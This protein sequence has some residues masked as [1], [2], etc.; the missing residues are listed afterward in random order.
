MVDGY[1][2]ISGANNYFESYG[3]SEYE[4]IEQTFTVAGGNIEELYLYFENNE[5]DP[6]V[7][8]FKI[9]RIDVI[10]TEPLKYEYNINNEGYTAPTTDNWYLYSSTNLPNTNTITVRVTN[11]LGEQET[12][13]VTYGIAIILSSSTNEWTNENVTVTANWSGDVTQKSLTCTGT[14]GTD[15]TLNGTT[16]VIVMTNKQTITATALDK[17]GNTITKTLKVSIIDKNAPTVQVVDDK[18]ETIEEG[19]SYG[20]ANYFTYNKNGDA[21]LEEVTYKVTGTG[22]SDVNGINITNINELEE[23][24]YTIKYTVTKVTGLTANATKNVTILKDGYIIED[25]GQI[26]EYYVAKIDNA[27]YIKVQNAINAVPTDNNKV[28]VEVIKDVTE[29]ITIP[30]N[31]NIELDLVDN[32]MN[33]ASNNYTITSNGR[34]TINRGT[35]ISSASSSIKN[36]GTLNISGTATVSGLVYNDRNNKSKW[37]Y[38]Y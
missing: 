4:I 36:N 26:P 29:D 28:T 3:E 12:K 15:Y 14:E 9:T 35:I 27:Y 1:I 17:A 19:K 10:V 7:A 20:V 11:G 24:N 30:A 21:P 22:I 32:T 23:G 38:N 5:E 2:E 8:S 31:T 6:T 13:T 16:N 37:R 33:G 25:G 34:L 18:T